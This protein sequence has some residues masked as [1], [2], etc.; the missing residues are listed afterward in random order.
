MEDQFGGRTDDDLFYDDFEPVE[1]G[2]TVIAVSDSANAE[3]DPKVVARQLL[4]HTQPAPSPAPAPAPPPQ[5]TIQQAPKPPPRGGLAFSRFADKPQ[6][7]P[8]VKASPPSLPPTQPPAQPQPPTQKET[9]TPPQTDTTSQPKPK[10]RQRQRQKQK[11]SPPKQ[12]SPQPPAT[13]APPAPKGK[14]GAAAAPA[15]DDVASVAATPGQNTTAKPD[16]RS[17]SGANPRQKLTDAELTEKLE[18]MKLLSAEKARKFEKAEKDQK[19]HEEAYARGME[20]ARKQKAEMAERR[21]INEEQRRKLEEERNKNRERKL[22][23]M[24]MKEGGWDEGKAADTEEESRRPFRGSNGGVRG[25]KSAGLGGSR[26]AK[27]SE[28]EKPSADRF[29]DDGGRRGG[30]GRGRGG[31]GRGRGGRGGLDGSNRDKS[32]VNSQHALSKDDFPSLPAGEKKEAAEATP[33]PAIPVPI[34]LPPLSNI[35]WDDEME[36]FD[37]MNKK[38]AS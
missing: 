3:P 6:E 26:F 19:Q 22:K 8:Q 5:I 7:K 31:N 2:P 13:K 17:R 16:V 27:S 28:E 34:E 35:K 30:R 33:K 37:E 25:A 24:S 15:N 29:L 23:A 14:K 38:A 20:E 18:K 11:Q 1:G 36:E 9:P 12:P 4:A 32:P 21:R 10:S